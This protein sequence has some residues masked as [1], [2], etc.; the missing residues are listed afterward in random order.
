VAPNLGQDVNLEQNVNLEQEQD[1]NLDQDV[2]SEQEQD[3]NSEQ[4]QD[5]NLEQEQEQESQDQTHDELYQHLETI[6]QSQNTII[7]VLFLI[8]FIV[9]LPIVTDNIDFIYGLLYPIRNCR[10]LLPY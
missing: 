9:G 1:V 5:V 10:P 4:E 6:I 3:V 8:L 7:Q 2:N